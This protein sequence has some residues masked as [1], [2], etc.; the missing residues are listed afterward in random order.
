MW[1]GLRAGQTTMAILRPVHQQRGPRLDR[2]RHRFEILIR[3]GRFMLRLRRETSSAWVTLPGPP[4]LD[5]S[6]RRTRRPSILYPRK[7]INDMLQDRL[8]NMHAYRNAGSAK[9]RA[10]NAREVAE[11][12]AERKVKADAIR[13][14]RRRSL[15]GPAIGGLLPDSNPIGP[16]PKD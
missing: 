11:V 2:V 7:E 5:L 16:K 12:K 6:D 1:P 8:M 13:G 9:V 10:Q 15:H 4:P 3:I 14:T